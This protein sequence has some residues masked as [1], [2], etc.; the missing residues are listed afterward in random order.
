[1]E[2]LPNLRTT[3][4]LKFLTSARENH[5]RQAE[6]LP[7]IVPKRKPRFD[8]QNLPDTQ[9]LRYELLTWDNYT[10]MLDL[11]QND[12]NPFVMDDFKTIEEL[13]MYAV[14]QLEYNWYS[15]KRGAC[16]WFLWAK[17]TN[18]LVGVLHLYD[19][20]WELYEGKHPS[21]TVGYAIGEKY[22][23]QGFAFEAMTHLLTQIPLI[24]KRYEVGANPK[25]ANIN[26]RYLLEKLG[27]T[28]HRE[29]GD[30]ESWW[31]KQLIEDIPL[32]TSDEVWEEEKKYR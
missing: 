27:F 9:Q 1:M 30:D 18:E 2:N 7:F 24:F 32:K 14:S 3:K 17:D 15:F 16:D 25:I 21:C 20:N 6:D 26:S 13:E 8:Y 23:R 28:E 10:Q 4:A 5:K 31:E 22:R 11:F 12:P 29:V 19:L